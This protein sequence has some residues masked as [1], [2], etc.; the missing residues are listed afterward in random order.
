M[1]G[2][3]DWQKAQSERE[4]KEQKAGV[5]VHLDRLKKKNTR[6]AQVKIKIRRRKYV[7]AAND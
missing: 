7:K 5:S 6:D 1:E 4:G 2:S 3:P